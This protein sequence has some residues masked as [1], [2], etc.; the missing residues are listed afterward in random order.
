MVLPVTSMIRQ[1]V[2]TATSIML[3]F[4]CKV[5]VRETACH[6]TTRPLTTNYRNLGVK[7]A[8]HPCPALGGQQLILLQIYITQTQQYMLLKH[9]DK[10]RTTTSA[11]A[12]TT[13]RITDS[14]TN[15]DQTQELHTYKSLKRGFC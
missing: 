8:S 11:T 14:S 4:L 9:S 6:L 15:T 7:M 2:R 12:I 5:G 13:T 10:T 1:E 3:G